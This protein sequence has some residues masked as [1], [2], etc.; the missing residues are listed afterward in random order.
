MLMSGGLNPARHA[1]GLAW[2][3]KPPHRFHCAACEQ[4]TVQYVLCA[5]QKPHLV[6]MATVAKAGNY[7]R[8][9]VQTCRL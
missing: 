8:F 1:G 7:A 5:A 2:N 3:A 9:P 6:Y 4:R